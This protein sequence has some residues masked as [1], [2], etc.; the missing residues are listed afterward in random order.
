[1][2]TS[3]GSG[4]VTNGSGEDSMPLNPDVAMCLNGGG[5]DEA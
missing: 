4:A 5:A 3:T 2:R 1:M